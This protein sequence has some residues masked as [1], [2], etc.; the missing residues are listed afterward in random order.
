MTDL[1]ENLI[2]EYT[3]NQ[4]FKESNLRVIFT[5]KADYTFDNENRM[6]KMTENFSSDINGKISANYKSEFIFNYKE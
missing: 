2:S 3:E 6:T 4:I 5:T 1:S